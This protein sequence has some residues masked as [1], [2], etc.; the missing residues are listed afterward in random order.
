MDRS[1]DKEMLNRILE[2]EWRIVYGLEILL[3]SI[4]YAL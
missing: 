4:G 1:R 2:S 3:I